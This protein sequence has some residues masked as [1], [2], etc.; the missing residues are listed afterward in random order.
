MNFDNLISGSSASSAFSKSGLEHLEVSIRL[1][2]KSGLE[3]FEH[4]L[5][6]MWN[7]GSCVVVLTFFGI[8]FLGD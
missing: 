2:L 8:A 1:L 4:Y 3:N 6:K 7:E 5:S